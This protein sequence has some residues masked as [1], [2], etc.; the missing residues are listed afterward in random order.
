MADFHIKSMTLGIGMGIILTSLVSMIYFEGTGMKMSKE[1]I[2]S[3]AKKYGMIDK[4]EIIKD[5]VKPASG[6]PIENN[7]IPPAKADNVLPKTTKNEKS[8]VGSE[9]GVS[10]PKPPVQNMMIEISEGDTSEIVAEKLYSKGI[11][12]DKRSFINKI[13][14]SKFETKIANGNFEFKPGEDY[15]NLIKVLTTKR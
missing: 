7:G 1:E 13:N 10:T 8:D 14:G 9:N 5:D 6:K 12:N 4:S 2:I 11:I 15:N 3:E